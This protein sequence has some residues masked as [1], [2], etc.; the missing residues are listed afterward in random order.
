[1]GCTV[2]GAKVEISKQ[3]TEKSQGG[4]FW[5]AAFGV[6]AYSEYGVSL[7]RNRASDVHSHAITRHGPD[8]SEPK[9]KSKSK[10]ES[11]GQEHAARREFL[12]RFRGTMK[13][14]L[15]MTGHFDNDRQPFTASDGRRYKFAYTDD[16]GVTR[17]ITGYPVG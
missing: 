7:E 17:E 6:D 16:E 12:S 15:S 9:Y 13:N 3:G 14:V 10:F 8:V 5:R 11:Y 1:M 4:A 2:S